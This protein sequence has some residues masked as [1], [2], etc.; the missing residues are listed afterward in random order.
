M[1]IEQ[2]YDENPARRASEEVEYGRDWHDQSG[3]RFELSWVKETGEVYVLVEPVPKE[4]A[5][6]FGGIHVRKTHR[7]DEDEV[8]EMSVSILGVVR[9][10]SV[11]ESVL[12]G[13][14][15]VMAIP[16]S[17]GWVVDRLRG[18]KILDA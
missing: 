8:H 1:N 14:Q 9:D 18:A 10:Q 16:D 12:E 6:P 5:T 7:I 4:W 3:I 15:E 17:I 2:F 13:W 11:F